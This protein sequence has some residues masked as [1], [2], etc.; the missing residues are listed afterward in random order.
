L[1]LYSHLK[2]I[3]VHTGPF[4]TNL[5]DNDELFYNLSTLN[6][7]YCNNDCDLDDYEFIK[8][9]ER[10][11]TSTDTT[12]TTSSP[13]ENG[14]FKRGIFGKALSIPS[15]DIAKKFTIKIAP[16]LFMKNGVPSTLAFRGLRSSV[17]IKMTI[18][19]SVMIDDIIKQRSIVKIKDVYDVFVLTKTVPTTFTKKYYANVNRPHRRYYGRTAANN[20]Q[21]DLRNKQ[22]GIITESKLLQTL[23]T[24]YDG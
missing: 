24:H 11:E 10:N 20:F 13:S 6:D 18:K 1:D 4:G 2:G 8:L 22:S 19:A 9:D 21:R 17:S 3:E 12:V 23:I 14:R 15:K 5:I 16:K 7:Q